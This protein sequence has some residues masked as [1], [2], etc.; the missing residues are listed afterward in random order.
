MA[1]GMELIA[2][3][4]NLST[5]EGQMRAKTVNECRTGRPVKMLRKHMI[6]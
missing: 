4:P 5:R 2:E 1:D 6:L 3:M